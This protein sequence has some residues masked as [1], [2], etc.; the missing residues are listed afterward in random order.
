V[1]ADDARVVQAT[2]VAHMPLVPEIPLHLITERCPLWWRTQE[3]LTAL[4]LPAPYWA[5][6]WPGGQA[7][8]RMLLDHPELV[9]GKRVLDFGAGGAVEGLAALRAGAAHVLAV[10]IDPLAC[11]AARLNAQLSQ[12]ELETTHHD[13]LGST[14]DWDVVLAGDVFYDRQMADRGLA[15]LRGLAGRGATVWIGDP[16]RGFLDPRGLLRAGTYSCAVDGDVTGQ[17]LRE[18]AVYCLDETRPGTDAMDEA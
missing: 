15:W 2:E 18:T 9:R 8:A 13:L 4:Q 3:Q 12:L 16:S 10:D 17:L 1:E 5:F 14:G 11:T 6:C 7:L